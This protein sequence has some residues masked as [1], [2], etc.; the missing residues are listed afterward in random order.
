[1]YFV[2]FLSAAS[3][4]KNLFMQKFYHS[5]NKYR[6]LSKVAGIYVGEKAHL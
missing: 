4:C 2:T 6:N 5:A 1:L 3:V